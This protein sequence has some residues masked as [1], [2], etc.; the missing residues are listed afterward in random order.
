LPLAAQFQDRFIR[1]IRGR[2]TGSIL[3]RINYDVGR[4]TDME[5]NANERKYIKVR[6]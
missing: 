4:V 2:E 1:A 3:L 6:K 5:M